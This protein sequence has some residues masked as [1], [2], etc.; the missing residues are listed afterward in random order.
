MEEL[1]N[2]EI[3]RIAEAIN[4]S[5]GLIPSNYLKELIEENKKEKMTEEE[6]VEKL[7]ENYSEKRNRR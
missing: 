2:E 1:T 7:K 3:W 5:D 6:M 4:K